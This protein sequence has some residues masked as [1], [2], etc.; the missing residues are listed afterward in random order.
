M[1]PHTIDRDGVADKAAGGTISN[2]QGSHGGPHG[3]SRSEQPTAGPGFLAMKNEGDPA[4]YI[5]PLTVR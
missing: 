3:H 5:D 2:V 1:H 4:W